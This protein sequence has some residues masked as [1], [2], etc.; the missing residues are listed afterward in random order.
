LL[1]M[2]AFFGFFTLVVILQRVF[3]VKLSWL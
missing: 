2:S 3:G 1:V